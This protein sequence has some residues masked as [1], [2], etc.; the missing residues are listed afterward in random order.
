MTRTKRWVTFTCSSPE[1]DAVM[2]LGTSKAAVLRAQVQTSGKTGGISCPDS[3]C[4]GILLPDT[5]GPCEFCSE[6]IPT[7]RS[8]RHKTR[9][10]S[11]ICAA[12]AADGEKP[13]S[14]PPAA[15]VAAP[16]PPAAPVEANTPTPTPEAVGSVAS[17]W[18]P[19][20]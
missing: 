10:C 18:N 3:A 2:K 15:P 14:A 4:L 12:R 7:F 11:P 5:L 8:G 13:A 20:T 6:S 19:A 17:I 16:T 1:C 9:W